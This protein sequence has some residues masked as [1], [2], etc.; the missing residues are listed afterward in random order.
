MVRIF[1]CSIWAKAVLFAWMPLSVVTLDE[2]VR[3]ALDN[4]PQVREAVAD[5]NAI[6]AKV[7]E[8]K[9]LRYPTLGFSTAT[10]VMNEAPEMKMPEIH[11]DMLGGIP[12]SLPNMPLIDTTIS[13]GALNFSMP[14]ITGGRVRHGVNQVKA[15][16]EAIEAGYE[17]VREEVAFFTIKAYLSAVL[18]GKVEHAAGEAYNTIN[19]HLRQAIRLFEERQI[20]RYEVLRAETEAANAKK[21]LTDAQNNRRLSTAFLQNLIGNSPELEIALDTDIALLTEIAEQYETQVDEAALNSYALEALEA[22]DR[23]YRE[24]EAGAKSERMPVLAAFASRVLYSNEQPFTIPSTIAGVVLNVPIFDGGT[25]GAKAAEQRA[26][27]E[28]NEYERIKT[29]NNLR[30]EVMQYTLDM[31]SSKSALESTE[32]SIETALESLRLAERR[33]AEGVGTGIEISDAALALLIAR[34]NEIQARYQFNL[35]AYGLAKTSGKL[36]QILNIE[37]MEK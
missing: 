14:I 11:L 27:R 21:R 23:M 34:T 13:I 5:V 25:S 31:E 10:V 15:G 36:W 4:N 9:S 2:A 17:A 26:L 8:V 22:K 29:Q 7:N 33:F 6:K 16:A 19:E 3:K 24:A 1:T 20:A 28:R 18:A 32:K 12:L 37:V 35:A 30:L